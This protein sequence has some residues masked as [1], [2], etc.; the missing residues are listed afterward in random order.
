ME[1]NKEKPAVNTFVKKH[2]RSIIIALIVIA[3]FVFL[4]VTYTIITQP[5]RSVASFC[6]VA[7]ENKSA[8]LPNA[9][10]EQRLSAYTKL[11]VVSPDEIRPDITAIKKGY[12]SAVK[13]PANAFTTGLGIAASEGRRTEY[14]NKHCTDFWN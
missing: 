6:K 14:L 2:K 3:A 8:L 7:K 1:S 12:E 13:D 9:N 5:E 10:N 4:T 11:E